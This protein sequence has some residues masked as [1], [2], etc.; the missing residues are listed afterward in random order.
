MPSR[1]SWKPRVA[2]WYSRPVFYV[3]DIERSLACYVGKLGFKEGWRYDEEGVRLIVQ[4]DRPGCELI[5]TAQWPDKVG[6]GLM[7]ISVDE[8]E[9]HV[10]RAQYEVA[11]ADV[12]DGRW[13]YDLMVVTDPDGYQLYFPYP[14]DAA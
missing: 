1:V 6:G 7:F 13:G 3:A 10:L 8:P 9:L 2:D 14:A 11:G 4:V 5:L 12:Q